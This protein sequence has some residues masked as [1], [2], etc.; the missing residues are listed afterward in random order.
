MLAKDAET[1]ETLLADGLVYIHSFGQIDD[2][3]RYVEGLKS[4]AVRYIA[5]DRSEVTVAV[6]EET[7]A[8]VTA[9]V[10]LVGELNGERKEFTNL[11]VTTWARLEDGWKLIVSQSTPLPQI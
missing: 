11:M 7:T 5:L 1:I 10:R 8:V 6:S 2:K 4:P 3:T 9:K